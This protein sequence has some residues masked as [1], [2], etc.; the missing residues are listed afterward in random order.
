MVT[1]VLNVEMIEQ[2]MNNAGKIE[3][4]SRDTLK[5]MLMGALFNENKFI[6]SDID[7]G[8]I[9]AFLFATIEK[10]DG[11][12]V[13]FIQACY[14]DKDGVVQMLL[15]QTIQWS[16]NLGLTKIVFMTKRNPKAWERKYKFSKSYSVMERVI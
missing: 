10:L 9:R 8:K 11:S 5:Q 14:S 15:N 16:K 2:I 6:I 7:D 3:G 4:I 13:C 1:D 12:D